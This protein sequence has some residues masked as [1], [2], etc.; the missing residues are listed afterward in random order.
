MIGMIGLDSLIGG[1][2]VVLFCI[3]YNAWPYCEK[4][5]VSV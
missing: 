2:V 5:S 3:T 1:I 4:W